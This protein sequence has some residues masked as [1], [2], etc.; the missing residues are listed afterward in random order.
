M[1]HKTDIMKIFKFTLLLACATLLVLT[2]GCD[3]HS[4][5]KIDEIKN[6]LLWEGNGTYGTWRMNYSYDF[7]DDIELKAVETLTLKKD[8]R[9]TEETLYLYKGD[10]LAKATRTGNWELDYDNELEAYFFDQDY[11]DKLDLQNLDMSDKWFK[12]FDTDLRLTINGDAYDALEDDDEDIIYGIEI[13]DCDKDLF[14]VK[15]LGYDE[16]YRYEPVKD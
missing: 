3:S 15:D 4:S 8:G 7:V 2:T 5:K 6:T 9:F 1:Q 13:I 14:L 16:I 12:R 11:N 10:A